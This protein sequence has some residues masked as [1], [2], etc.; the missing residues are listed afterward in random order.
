MSFA[1]DVAR[2]IAQLLDPFPDWL[3]V[4]LVSMLPV[5]ELRGGIPL[6]ILFLGMPWW[7]VY[8]LAVVA[9]IAVVPVIW[10]VLGPVER[11]LRHIGFMDRFLT[12]LFERTRRKST[13]HIEAYEEL[14][15]F[16]FVAVPL[17]GT[18]AWTGA[19]IA[20]LFDLP[21]RKTLFVIAAAVAVAG[22]LVL[23]LIQGGIGILG[24]A[25]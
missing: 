21:R 15:V 11:L 20:Y 13:K 7:T 16:L 14:G 2:W 23:A 22:L 5:A 1:Q 9:N 8:I 24:I 3:I 10:W 19:L 4:M 17:P 18:G 6:G 12:W 25:S